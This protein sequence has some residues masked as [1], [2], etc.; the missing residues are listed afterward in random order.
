[1]EHTLS[2]NTTGI[3][4]R[5]ALVSFL[6]QTFA[7]ED[8]GTVNDVSRYTYYVETLND[9]SRI[10]LRRPAPLNKGIDFTVNAENYR[11]PAGGR[12]LHNPSHDNIFTMLRQK[13]EENSVLYD[14]RVKPMI[15]RIFNVEAI[16]NAD[17]LIQGFS[18]AP[19][20]VELILKLLKW[21]FAEQD[22]TYWNK[23]GRW[24]LFN[25]LRGEGL[26]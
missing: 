21:L 3:I 9:G 11:F 10:Y 2:L 6:Y 26:A 12:S 16:D 19:Y 25:G 23:S 22:A 18:E 1:M 4:G 17:Y 13:R 7:S 14:A 15:E 20:S 5:P 8:P 24:M